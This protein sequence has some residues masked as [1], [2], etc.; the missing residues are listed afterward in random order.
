MVS[1]DQTLQRGSR[2]KLVMA[3]PGWTAIVGF[4]LRA[5]FAVATGHGSDTYVCAGRA[6]RTLENEGG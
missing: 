5:V 4:L 2:I 1:P 6:A 3:V